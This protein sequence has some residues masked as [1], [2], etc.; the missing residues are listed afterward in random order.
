MNAA[1]E[2]IDRLD[3][4][5]RAAGLDGLVP[6]ADASS[7]DALE[8]AIAPNSLPPDLRRF[9]ERVEF[10]SMRARGY[11]LPEPCDPRGALDVNHLNLDPEVFP[12]YGPPLLFPIA[13]T[14]GDQWSIELASEWTAGGIVFSHDDF[15]MRI[16]YPSFSDLIDVYADLLEAGQF[17]RQE[18]GEGLYA[19]LHREG[20]QE[21]QQAKIAATLPHVLY[22][23]RHEIGREPSDWPAHWLASA[24][25]DPNDRKPLGV[26][27]TIAELVDA[28]E[29]GPVH[30]RIAGEVVRLIGLGDG[31][32][33]IVTDGTRPLDVW[34]PAGTSLWGPAMSRRF[35]FEVAVA[36]P[37]PRPPDVDSGHR[38]LQD[39][40]LAGRI[41][42]ASIAA[43]A[44]FGRLARHRPAAVASGIRPLD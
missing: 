11:S 13:R 9:W 16:E 19:W 42:A 38:E 41:E 21:R 43:D 31:T 5:L 36:Q 2:T 37:I 1:D 44:M 29:L 32:L 10:S 4:A 6:A 25:I 3:D 39:H 35:E 27:H 24:G 34:C 12:L 7:L 15:T 14:S 30:A 28:A 18:N 23:D 22:G 26:T 8:R 20:E 33:V 17:V 40:A